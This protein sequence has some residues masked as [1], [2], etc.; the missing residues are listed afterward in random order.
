MIRVLSLILLIFL[1]IS[2]LF[3][4]YVLIKDPTGGIIQMPLSNLE[5]SPF[6]DFLI[7]GII[8]FTF[9]GLF[10]LAIFVLVLVRYRYSPWL[11]IFQGGT[12]FTWIVVQLIMIQGFHYFHAIY[13]GIGILLIIVGW[14]LYRKK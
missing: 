12:L 14:M 5:H 3:G 8:L 10:S 11:V 9:N 6:T 4:G 2:A 7:P 1:A 13:G